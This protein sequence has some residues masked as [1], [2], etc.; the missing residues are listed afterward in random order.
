MCVKKIT[1][2]D[3][4][5]IGYE[6]TNGKTQSRFDRQSNGI[7]SFRFYFNALMAPRNYVKLTKYFLNYLRIEW[8]SGFIKITSEN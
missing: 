3:S 7:N 6:W 8:F 5:I 2:T 4:E 1:I